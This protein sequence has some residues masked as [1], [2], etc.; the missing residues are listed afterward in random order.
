MARTYGSYDSHGSHDSHGSQIVIT[1]NP[2]KA[3]DPSFEHVG[4]VW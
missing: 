2:V 4:P 3:S 1:H